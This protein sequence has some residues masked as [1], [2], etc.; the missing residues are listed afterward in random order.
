[1]RNQRR[2]G[3]VNKAFIALMTLIIVVFAVSAI[4]TYDY[5]KTSGKTDNSFT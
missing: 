5:Y 2:T 4:P 3:V 1:M